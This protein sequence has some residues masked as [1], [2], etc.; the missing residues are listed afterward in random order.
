MR[1]RIIYTKRKKIK[2]PK[3]SRPLKRCVHI[4]GKEWRWEFR[5][6]DTELWNCYISIL[7]PDNEYFTVYK[8]EIGYEILP[9]VI[10]QYI[11]DNL[12]QVSVY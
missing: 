4:D 9:S 7:S 10:K 1:H 12:I 2:N 5:K 6:C 11:I 3:R 8:R